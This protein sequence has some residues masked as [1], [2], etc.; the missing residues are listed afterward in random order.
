[1]GNLQLVENYKDNS[2]LRLSFNNLAL[3]TF[4][5]DFEKWYEH[6][7]WNERYVCY[8]FV[9][10]GEIVANASI[11]KMELLINGQ[12]KQALQLGT[13][14]TH[15][16][17]RKR[18]L[19]AELIQTILKEQEANYDVIF[20]FANPSVLD[21]YPKLGF[22]P[23]QESLFSF[24]LAEYKEDSSGGLRKLDPANKN[25]LNL[26]TELV[27]ERVPNSQLFGA[28]QTQHITLWYMLTIFNEAIYYLEAEQTIVIGETEQD[29]LHLYDVISRHEV[30]FQNVINKM[31]ASAIREVIFH[32]T[33]D[34]K[35]LAVKREIS[36]FDDVLFVKTALELP[37]YF[38]YPIT[39]QA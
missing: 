39:S 34:C 26:I 6:G 37:Q 7:F 8:S 4:G 27:A 30:S 24:E 9:D 11:N 28:D 17:Y 5:I 14:M 13:V 15:P 19:A 23:V 36:A 35:E 33:I 1:M 38:K 2:Q 12:I 16:D 10:N 32:F 22:V 20:L 25:D 31:A 3:Q 18:G 29:Q 21:F